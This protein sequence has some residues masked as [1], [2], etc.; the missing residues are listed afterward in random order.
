VPRAL[1]RDAPQ[2]T[3]VIGAAGHEKL[4][5]THRAIADGLPADFRN[6]AIPDSDLPASLHQQDVGQQLAATERAGTARRELRAG[7]GSPGEVGF[8][9]SGP[10]GRRSTA[11]P[12][13]RIALPQR[14]PTAC[15]G[16]RDARDAA[17]AGR[18]AIQRSNPA[19]VATATRHV[20][21][22]RTR[23]AGD[24]CWQSGAAGPGSHSHGCGLTRC[25]GA[26]FVVTHR[27]RQ[28]ASVM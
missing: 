23:A 8:A 6:I 10:G 13:A 4:L 1:L 17:I 18:R 22:G 9:A 5:N 21:A 19:I 16:R 20:V 26:F 7:A 12:P 25:A 15:A 28:A 3:P 24:D 14:A 2:L 27:A 11:S